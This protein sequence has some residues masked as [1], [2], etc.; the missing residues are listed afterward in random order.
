MFRIL[1]HDIRKLHFSTEKDVSQTAGK[2]LKKASVQ[3]MKAFP[4]FFG[5]VYEIGHFIKS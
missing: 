4:P 5:E 1:G 2:F 3:A